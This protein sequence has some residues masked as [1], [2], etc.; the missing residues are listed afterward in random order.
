MKTVLLTQ[1]LTSQS[2]LSPLSKHEGVNIIDW[3][4]KKLNKMGHKIYVV[5]DHING[6]QV[7]LKSKHI[8][9]C[10]FVYD[11][12]DQPSA[13]TQIQAG[14]CATGGDSYF[15]PFNT[16]CPSHEVW[17][18]IYNNV[19]T[20]C[21]KNH[22][23]FARPYCPENGTIISGS[24]FY[25]TVLGKQAFLKLD[26]NTLDHS[27]LRESKVPVLNSEIYSLKSFDFVA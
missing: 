16:L 24:P 27:R 13:F 23:H 11:T 12:V 10:E 2:S 7:L 1:T 21:Y 4:I 19:A 20:K 15:L 18:K 22:S 26:L 8:H 25:I 6:E 3:Q 9:H 14:L 5:L 17:S